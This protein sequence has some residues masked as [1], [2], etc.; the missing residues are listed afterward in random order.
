MRI[1]ALVAGWACLVL[2]GRLAAQGT[3]SLSDLDI[4]LTETQL[5]LEK[6]VAENEGLRR[7]VETSRRT[8][9]TLS[10]SLALANAEAEVFRRECKELRLR[11]E[12]LGLEGIEADPE[13]LEQ[14]LLKAVRD[15]RVVHEQKEQLADQLVRM[16]E[17]LLRFLSTVKEADAVARMELETELRRA[18]ELLGVSVR[19]AAEAKA[20]G[21]S[22]TDALVI[23]LNDK[24]S[25]VVANVGKR[26]GVR[27]G[28][29]FEVWREGNRIGRVR[30][31]DVREEISG[32][33]VQYLRSDKD[34]IQV[35]DRLKI[36]TY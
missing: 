23:S 35:G 11:M 17:A 1:P 19:P 3:G 30:V 6:A 7:E 22:L 34:K 25:L 32:A 12:A 14:R 9:A 18:N 29:S 21:A 27:T 8:I 16:T 20:S 31:V 13:R 4:E 26:H 2:A 24:I 5:T 10:E 36:E 15:L 28:M 33:V